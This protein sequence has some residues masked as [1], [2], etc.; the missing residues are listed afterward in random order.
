MRPGQTRRDFLQLLGAG[1]VF[2]VQPFDVLGALAPAQDV[3]NPLE[4]YPNRGWEQVYRDQ[5]RYDRTFTWVCAPNDTHMCRMKAFVRNG[6]MI[7][8]EQNYDHQRCG[9]LYGNRATAAWNPRG[10]PKG[11]T[12]QRRVY[13]PFRLKGPVLRKGWKEWADAGFPSLSDDP[14][15][16]SQYRFDD[17][18]ND[19]YVRLSWDEVSDY[20]ARGLMAVARTYSGDEGKRRLTRDG[21]A[22]EMLEHW[23]GAGT[24]TMKIGSNLPIH[25]L[26]GKFGLFRFANQMGLLDHHVRKVPET[27]ALGAREWTEYTW[28]GDQA[29]GQPFVHGLQTS[30]CDMNDVRHSKLTIHIGKNLVENKMPESHWVNELMERGGKI[31][32]ITPDYSAPS[33]KADYWIGVRPGLSDTA[34]V[35]AVTKILMDRHWIDE[36][37]VKRFTDFPLLVRT[38]TLR[39]LRPEE[40]LRG[41]RPKDISGG[42]S[43]TQQALTPE[44]RQ[45]IGDF[46]AWD[47]TLGMVV[48]LSRDDV[49]AHANTDVALTGTYPVTTVDGARI[50]VMPV[51]EMYKR[52]LADYDTQTVEE[53]SGA[54]AELVE[55]LAQDIW[56]TTKAGHSVA[57]HHGEGVNHY[58]HATLH[59]RA[60]HL[61]LMLTG[62][63]GK[64]G[65]GVFTWAG[66]YKGALLQGSPWSGPGAGTYSH[67][68]PFH[69]VL[70]AD[71]R[72]T[73]EQL[74]DT[75][76]GEDVAYWGHGETPLIVQTQQGRRVFTGHTHMPSPTKLMWYSN[77]NFLNQAKW[78]YHLI[79][80]VLPKID[81]IV[82][83][84]VEWTG[85]AEYADVVLPANTWVE[86]QDLEL[87]GS[88]SNPFL[89]VWGGQGIA[90]VHDSRD[91]AEIFA[92]VGRAL[93]KLTGDGRFADY[94][95][96]ITEKQ[97]GV[98]IQRVLD[99]CTTTRGPQGAY[100]LDRLLKGEYGGEPG[101]AL[102]L[103]RTYPRVPFWEQVHDSVPFYTDCG[104]LAGYCDLPEAIE[105]G[106]NLVVHREAVEATPYLPNVIV[107]SS[108]YLRPADYGIA[109]D[110]LDPDRRSVRNLML[111]W[112]E[113]KT[114]VNPLWAQGFR[115]FCS[116]PKSRHT[117]HSSW[118]TVDWH[119]IWSTNFGDPLRRDKRNPGT[120]DRQIQMNPQAAA[121]LGLTEGDYVWVDANPADRPFVGASAGGARAKAFRCMVR[122]KLNPSLPY[123]MTIMKHTG[124][125]ATERTVKAHETRP[126]GMALSPE[127]GYQSNYRYG[128]HQSITRSWL[129][130][131]HQTDT[132]FHKKTGAMGFT[133]GFAVDNHGV[134]T[135]PK[136]TLVRITK[137]EAGG[138]GGVGAW[139]P[140]TT[141][142]TPGAESAAM[143]AYLRGEL[144]EVRT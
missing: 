133:F 101:A 105:Y 11:F 91:D 88:C 112:S 42:P 46:T 96:Y 26:V 17:R 98:Y 110:D 67:E 144:T 2:I 41:Y 89:Q 3:G 68:D 109:R 48:P 97:A 61:P 8:S 7:R 90:P 126:D 73:H 74:R 100:R 130:P 117:T 111:P 75:T 86:A 108:P 54:K 14:S 47:T 69:P 1:A 12:F 116:T 22:P 79:A 58:F 127:T 95:K 92:G 134:N 23:K 15:L 104:R 115:F 120:G 65:A 76:L 9:D 94:W 78:V 56:E 57:I 62:N 125:I 113:V 142:R 35:L 6:V 18:G 52:H 103:F 132:L 31:V 66:N 122:L 93:A 107:S 4:H 131:M 19:G 83:Q 29:P 143:L 20:V 5:Y 114:T 59:N 139:E 28:R 51:Y 21:Y 71:V 87:G 33:A 141:G 99:N 85:S 40:V 55:R 81:M 140:A 63:F 30:D 84:Q 72:L 136:E 50:E 60:C 82:D 16:R 38:D 138:L 36:D 77:A 49:G 43:F 39:R 24:R 129:P 70:D 118:S 106:E 121:D 135:V 137:A 80:N 34:V 37:F 13:G 45:R 53:I 10:C 124:W 44:Q 25:G 64:H 32:C 119:W 128:S 27:E 123:T 102:M